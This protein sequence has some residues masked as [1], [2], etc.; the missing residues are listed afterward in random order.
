M[1]KIRTEWVKI[2]SGLI[3]SDFGSIVVVFHQLIFCCEQ[4][5]KLERVKNYLEIIVSG[6]Q[7]PTCTPTKEK[8]RRW[9]K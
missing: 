7:N 5:I 1:A 6:Y 8:K 2:F 4:I 3:I 9:M